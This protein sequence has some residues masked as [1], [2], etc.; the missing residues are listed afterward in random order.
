M[1]KRQ[2]PR[3]ASETAV[4][5][6]LSARLYPDIVTVGVRW[7]APFSRHWLL[8]NYLITNDFFC[9]G[10]TFLC[11]DDELAKGKSCHFVGLRAWLQRCA[12]VARTFQQCWCTWQGSSSS[13]WPWAWLW[14]RCGAAKV[15]HHQTDSPHSL[16]NINRYAQE[17][18]GLILIATE[19]D[20]LTATN[21][22]DKTNHPLN[23]RLGHPSY[24]WIRVG[25]LPDLRLVQLFNPATW[26]DRK[27]SDDCQDDHLMPTIYWLEIKKYLSCRVESLHSKASHV[28][29]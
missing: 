18:K 11:F 1:S 8:S 23:T 22:T 12:T 29:K 6:K 13:M 2:V 21:V 15:S 25:S 20:T 19:P 14:K 27:S 5:V 3:A 7:R 10:F 4:F 24:V 16:W 17:S 26:F 9:D 28:V